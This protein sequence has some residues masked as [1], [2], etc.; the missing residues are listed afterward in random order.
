[1]SHI[2]FLYKKT[3]PDNTFAICCDTQMSYHLYNVCFDWHVFYIFA[4]L[5]QFNNFVFIIVISQRFAININT[6]LCNRL[7]K[8]TRNNYIVFIHIHTHI[9]N[10][11]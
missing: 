2:L 9:Y 4:F 5:C 6:I 7:S 11:R 8:Y 1:M 10:I 3:V